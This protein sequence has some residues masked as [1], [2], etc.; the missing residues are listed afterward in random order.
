MTPL[1]DFFF[2]MA[3]CWQ[4]PSGYI[5]CTQRVILSPPSVWLWW[6][7]FFNWIFVWSPSLEVFIGSSAPKY[8]KMLQIMCAL[9]SEACNKVT[10]SFH[11]FTDYESID[12]TSHFSQKISLPQKYCARYAEGV[13][14]YTAI[15]NA[16][17]ACGEIFRHVLFTDVR[18]LLFLVSLFLFC[19]IEES[20]L[21][22]LRQLGRWSSLQLLTKVLNDRSS[23]MF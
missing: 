21:W 6:F 3:V 16:G 18:I 12:L 5:V 23:C 19:E 2:D 4:H 1:L 14:W 13:L 9:S 20:F 10:W 15:S 11:I 7:L 8:P 17:V 22:K